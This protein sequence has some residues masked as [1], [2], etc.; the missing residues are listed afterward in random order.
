MHEAS[1]TLPTW[2]APTD[3]QGLA[4]F[5]AVYHEWGPILARKAGAVVPEP[6]SP[7]GVRAHL[8]EAL[9]T[10]GWPTYEALLREHS[11]RAGDARIPFAQLESAY[12]RI[13]ARS[14]R[15]TCWSA[16]SATRSPS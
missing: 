15:W 14:A 3:P 5:L 4:D 1:D 8:G 7:A 6:A 2:L 13:L 10:G 9:R 16:S 11:R 12:G